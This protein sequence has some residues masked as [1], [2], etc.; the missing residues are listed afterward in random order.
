[1]QREGRD[2]DAEFERG[3][4]GD[5]ACFKGIHR[6]QLTI[7]LH[8]CRGNSASRWYTEGGYD[9]I[10]EKLFNLLDVDR[11]LLE[12]DTERAGSFDPLRMF[13]RNKSVVLGLVTTKEPRL[14]SQ[15]ELR[16]R[17]DEAGRYV[18]LENLALSPQCGFASVAAGNLISH[19]DQWQKLELIVETARKVWGV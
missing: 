1:M 4:Q 14:E 13:P 12:Y 19:D 7:A 16:R 5:N 18:P 11:Y 15:D 8:V 2:P 10:A 6:D 17:I 9:V 3:I